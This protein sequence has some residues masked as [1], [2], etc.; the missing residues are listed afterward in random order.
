M[1][2]DVNLRKPVKEVKLNC[3]YGY[4]YRYLNFDHESFFS[5]TFPEISSKN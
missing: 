5:V 1:E 3:K 4:T 2:E